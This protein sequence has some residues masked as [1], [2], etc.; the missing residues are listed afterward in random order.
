[1]AVALPDDPRIVSWTD[2]YA[3]RFLQ[4]AY[5]TEAVIRAVNLNIEKG[6]IP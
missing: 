1:M 5:S 2:G 3:K 6:R 4:A